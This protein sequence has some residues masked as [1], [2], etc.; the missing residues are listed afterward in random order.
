M[1]SSE[2]FERLFIRYKSEA[3]PKGESIQTFCHRNNVPYNLFEKWYKDTR[4]K[5]VEVKVSGRPSQPETDKPEEE[6]RQQNEEKV[7]SVQNRRIARTDRCAYLRAVNIKIIVICTAVKILKGFSSVTR[8]RPIRRA[9]ASRRSVIGTM[10][11]TT[12]LRNG[13]RIRGTRSW[14]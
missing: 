8:V 14:K 1:Y 11:P 10:S 12:C 5:V 4:H 7:V 2:D 6:G 9:R 13:T 3:Y